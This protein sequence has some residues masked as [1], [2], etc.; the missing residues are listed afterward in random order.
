MAQDVL[1]GQ[2]VMIFPPL[3][4]L[5]LGRAFVIAER[6]ESSFAVWY[7]V[8][9]RG[10]RALTELGPKDTVRVRGPL[11]NFFPEPQEGTGLYIV[12]GAMGAAAFALSRKRRAEWHLGVPDDSWRPLA[13]V[14]SSRIEA[15]G[16]LRLFSE[17]G[18][19]GKKGDALRELP[20][21]LSPSD[22]LWGCGP[23]GMLKALALKY[24]EQ[25]SQLFFSLEAKMA[26]GYGG[27][28]GCVVDTLG[29]KKRVCADGPIFRADEVIWDAV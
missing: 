12:M 6:T 21:T 25:Q 11:G 22:R 23:Y 5:L 4:S 8:V 19:L 24:K 28:L 15:P 16:S 13:A 9:G 27:C 2:F 26:C 17:D 18:S 20:D 7:R 14:F 3:D 10:T 1:T 29:G